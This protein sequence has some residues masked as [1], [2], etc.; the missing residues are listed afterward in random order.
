VPRDVSHFDALKG[1]LEL[2]RAEERRRFAADRK[3]LPLEELVARGRLLLD[4]ESRDWSVGLGGRSL[5]TF[6]QSDG[7]RLST[8]LSPG[9]IV[10]VSP[11]K[12]EVESPPTGL[13]ARSTARSVQ[14]AFD[15]PPPPFVSEGRLRLDVLANDVTFDRARNALSAAAAMDKGL[16]R[17]RREV[18]LGNEPPAFDRVPDFA[19]SRPLNPEQQAAV[20]RALSAN[21]VFLVHGP[22][23][24]G[25]SHVLAEIAVQLVRQNKR[26]LCTAASN[27]AVDHLLEL[28][29]AGG[30]KAIRVGHPARVLPHLQEHTLDLLVEDHE[31]RKLARELFDDAFDLLGYARKQRDRGRSRERFANAREAQAEAR[32]LM[33]EARVLERKAVAAVLGSAQVVCS[34]LATLEGP[35]LWGER[36]DVALLDEATQAI[37]P[38]ALMAYLKAERL[39][40]AGDPQQLAPTVMAQ[41]AKA[42]GVSLFERLLGDFGEGL[43]QLLREQHR[44]P[45][46]LMEFPS[47]EMYGGQLRAHPDVAN[48][49]LGEL[50]PFLFIDTA[51]KGFDEAA[52][53]GS[54]SL[55]NVGEAK[56]LLGR[57]RLLLKTL[58]PQELGVI[59]PYRAQA[60]LIRE[61]LRNDEVEVDTVDAF[62]GREKTAVL[63]SLV[64]SNTEGRLGFLEDLRRINVAI[65]RAK[66]HLFVVGDSATLASH[67]FYARL[68][69]HAQGTGAYRSAWEWPEEG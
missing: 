10:A 65:T 59:T 43:K 37:E 39:I 60:E 24:T 8:R 22:P 14:V 32:R 58:P 41:E 27:A 11:R 62:Q 23:G 66:R 63:V 18:L 29:L 12:A 49:T 54:E 64:R 26:V 33:D 17:R 40:L 9:D 47:R 7:R 15:R 35:V 67:A 57:A 31:S 6:E 34:T 1:L 16:A 55:T 38:L 46:A 13:V 2:E 56:L 25:K 68:I 5:V 20:G 44:F 45:V 21:D 50:P 30:L 36:F 48:A 19:P 42:L 28:C 3:D 52:A 53:E 61:R 51:G 69:E 4:V